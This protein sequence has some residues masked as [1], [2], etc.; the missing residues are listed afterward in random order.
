MSLRAVLLLLLIGALVS[1]G[2]LNEFL[3]STRLVVE[4]GSSALIV[5]EI[6]RSLQ[7]NHLTNLSLP[8]NHVYFNH[9][10]LPDA[11]VGHEP[12]GVSLQCLLCNSSTHPAEADRQKRCGSTPCHSLYFQGAHTPAPSA[13]QNIVHLKLPSPR[14]PDFPSFRDQSQGKNTPSAASEGFVLDDDD[15][16]DVDIETSW[17]GPVQAAVGE[18]DAATPRLPSD[19]EGTVSD[20]GGSPSGEEVERP[21]DGGAASELVLTG[22]VKQSQKNGPKSSNGDTGGQV[23]PGQIG[24]LSPGKRKGTGDEHEG[25]PNSKKPRKAP[26]P[27]KRKEGAVEK[28]N[29]GKSVSKKK[30]RPPD[31]VD[32]GQAQW[33][34][35]SGLMALV[36]YIDGS[37]TSGDVRHHDGRC[38]QQNEDR[39]MIDTSNTLQCEKRSKS[40]SQCQ[41]RSKSGAP[42]FGSSPFGRNVVLRWGSKQRSMDDIMRRSV[43]SAEKNADPYERECEVER[44]R[45]EA[46]KAARAEAQARHLAATSACQLAPQRDW[47]VAPAEPCHLAPE[48]ESSLTPYRQ[49]WG[50][51][52]STQEDEWAEWRDERSCLPTEP[53]FE[54]QEH[55]HG[56]PSAQTEAPSERFSFRAAYGG[57]LEAL[58][59][60]V[61]IS[62][63]L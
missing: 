42:S 27:A 8:L 62:A 19:E 6:Q 20:Q 63:D 34:K 45:K 39:R 7:P 16:E 38:A 30:T 24:M 61:G 60:K 18:G 13:P 3:P 46:H 52:E 23:R 10:E 48:Q 15:E 12:L 44:Q 32:D 11:L 57:V 50:A 43:D 21:P 26:A 56:F 1:V 40:D 29:S 41:K 28:K 25:S 35:E 31:R 22:S 53:R 5:D 58:L 4:A 49:S 59:R 2:L 54:S 14:T 55:G 51:Q 36:R 37:E 17:G 9:I 47:H 33:T